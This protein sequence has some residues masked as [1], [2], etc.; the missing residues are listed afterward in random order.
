MHLLKCWLAIFIS[1]LESF[2][3]NSVDYFNCFLHFL[4]VTYFRLKLIFE[5]EKAKIFSH[6]VQCLSTC[7]KFSLVVQYFLS[8]EF[9]FNDFES[10]LLAIRNSLTAPIVNSISCFFFP[11][12]VCGL[13]EHSPH[14]LIDFAYLV[15]TLKDELFGRD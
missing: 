1:S 13:N 2:L 4:I 12:E 6:S 3:F 11:L 10:Y 5:K 14:R 9:T 7:F 8:H 15:A